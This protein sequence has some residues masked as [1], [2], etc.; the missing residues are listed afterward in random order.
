MGWS[1]ATTNKRKLSKEDQLRGKVIQCNEGKSPDN[2]VNKPTPKKQ[3]VNQR[4]SKGS[5]RKNS[6]KSVNGKREASKD[7]SMV[8]AVFTENED[9]V[10]LQVEGDFDSEFED[11]EIVNDGMEE[12][13]N[14]NQNRLIKS[15][16]DGGE[17]TSAPRANE[18]VQSSITTNNQPVE[19]SLMEQP[20]QEVLRMEDINR[21]IQQSRESA[22]KTEKEEMDVVTK[23]IAGET[24]ALVK[25]MMEQAGIM[26]AASLVKKQIIESKKQSQSIGSKGT[27]TGMTLTVHRRDT[28]ESLSQ[29]DTASEMTIYENAVK[30]NTMCGKVKVTRFSSSSD[31]GLDTSDESNIEMFDQLHHFNVNDSVLSGGKPS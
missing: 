23:K 19:F 28:G 22:E 21:A 14:E 6:T 15:Y 27:A 18:I 29:I 9:V 2:E 30:D 1:R 24:F 3:K 16:G 11:G 31:E 8:T 13:R 12:K 17:G 10:T 25:E 4:A 5:E 26:D 7:K 20:R